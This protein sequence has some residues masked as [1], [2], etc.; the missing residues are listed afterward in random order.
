LRAAIPNTVKK[1]T[2][3]PSEST[4]PAMNAA[5]TPPTSAIGSVR[6]D[7]VASRQLLK[8]TCSSNRIAIAVPIEKRSMRL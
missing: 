5:S 8:D 7:M 6:K 3:E 4:P 1:P 2:S